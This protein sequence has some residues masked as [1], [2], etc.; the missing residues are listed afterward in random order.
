MR[1]LRLPGCVVAWVAA[2]VRVLNVVSVVYRVLA[3][4]VRC[5]SYRYKVACFRRI[6]S[7]GCIAGL[8]CS[9]LFT[10]SPVKTFIFCDFAHCSWLLYLLAKWLCYIGSRTD[11]GYSICAIRSLA[12]ICTMCVWNLCMCRWSCIPWVSGGRY[13]L[14][15]AWYGFFFSLGML[16]ALFHFVSLSCFYH[17]LCFT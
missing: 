11:G 6:H 1:L 7:W 8:C 5:W 15:C 2:L 3:L 13:I 17:F 14:T 10:D 12:Y 4:E 16:L 9:C